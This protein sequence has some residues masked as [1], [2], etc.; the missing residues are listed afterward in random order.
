M[1]KVKIFRCNETV[2]ILKASRAEISLKN[3]NSEGFQ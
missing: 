1:S 2:E 3:L